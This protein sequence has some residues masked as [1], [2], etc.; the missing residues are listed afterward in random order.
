MIFHYELLILFVQVKKTGV[1][2]HLVP[3]STL[4]NR[5]IYK[6]WPL[7]CVLGHQWYFKIYQRYPTP[8]KYIQIADIIIK[9]AV[10]GDIL[11]QTLGH[12]RAGREQCH[13]VGIH[14]F[15]GLKVNVVQHTGWH[16]WEHIQTWAIKMEA[17][18]SSSNGT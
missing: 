17:V 3:V 8:Q 15:W 10:I 9:P 7:L 5:S 1:T 11:Q 12:I 2:H 14:P 16:S 4:I 13:Q 6:S 18:F